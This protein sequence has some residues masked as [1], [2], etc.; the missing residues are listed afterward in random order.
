MGMGVKY[1]FCSSLNLERNTEADQRDPNGLYSL[2]SKKN[3]QA[4][5]L[6]WTHF[7]NSQLDGLILPVLL[8]R[9]SSGCCE[10]SVKQVYGIQQGARSGARATSQ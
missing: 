5:F 4:F 8:L 7:P 6:F 9:V 3:G 10:C 1:H 2:D